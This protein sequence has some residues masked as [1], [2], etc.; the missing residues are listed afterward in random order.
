MDEDTSLLA[1]LMC[2]IASRV[3]IHTCIRQ[4]HVVKGGCSRDYITS[5]EAP[6]AWGKAVAHHLETSSANISISACPGAG[7]NCSCLG[8]G[9]LHAQVLS[10]AC[11]NEFL[12]TRPLDPPPTR[13]QQH[14]LHTP[15]H[16]TGACSNL[17]PKSPVLMPPAA[18]APHHCNAARLALLTTSLAWALI[19]QSGR[20]PAKCVANR[21]CV[22]VCHRSVVVRCHVPVKPGR[23]SQ[24]SGG[25][26][27]RPAPATPA[28]PGD[29]VVEG[30]AASVVAGGY[31]QG[32]GGTGVVVR[33]HME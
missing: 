11:G 2:R 28:T 29:Q 3:C 15:T 19:L 17:Q 8:P 9:T 32:C 31:V 5:S 26:S 16:H 22:C 7:F 18:H 6:P 13:P 1:G 4:Q 10:C 21:M 24:P 23:R 12:H 25:R 33:T 14:T 27:G 20:Q 30:K